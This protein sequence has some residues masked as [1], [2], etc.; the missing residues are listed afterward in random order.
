MRAYS[1]CAETV[2][3]AIEVSVPA[4]TIKERRKAPW[5]TR[6]FEKLAK[7]W[8][9]VSSR[10]LGKSNIELAGDDSIGAVAVVVAIAS[11]HLSSAGTGWYYRLERQRRFLAGWVFWGWLLQ[12]A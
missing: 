3:Q 5:S 7:K 4:Y 11:R 6:G 2:T 10:V 8:E 9:A 1:M 12:V